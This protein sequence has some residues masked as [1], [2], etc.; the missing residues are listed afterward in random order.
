MRLS[1]II[2]LLPLAAGAGA[3][4]FNR[5]IRPILSGRCFKCHGFDAGARKA[6][7]RLD[8]REEAMKVIESGEFMKRVTSAD[9]DSIMPPPEEHEP[10]SAA[11]IA[12]LRQWIDEGAA[13]Q[14]HWAFIPPV[15]QPGTTID[16][17]VR[18]A[19]DREKLEP[20]PEADPL[21]LIRRASL[22]LTGLPPEAAAAHDPSLNYEAWVDALLASPH[23]GERLALDWLDAARYA[24]TNGY[25]TDAERQ[26][27]PWRDW[28]INAFN[29][30][31][32]FDQFTLEQ[33]AG[34]LLPDATVDQ[35]IATA[36]NRNHTVTNETG[37]IDEEY[38]AS[39]VSDRVETTAAT[40]LGL[41][42]GCARC[43]DHKYDPLTQRDYFSLYAAFNSIDEKGIIKEAAPMGAAPALRLP[44]EAQTAEL[45]ALAK[46]I[47]Q[48][49][50]ELKKQH[51]ALEAEIASWEPAA[52]AALPPA[53]V[54]GSVAH[55]S[56][57]TDARDYGPLRVDS[58][59][60]GTLVPG[61]GVKG[62]ATLLDATQYVEFAAPR[63]VERD[64]SF[65]LSVWINPGSSPQGCVASKQD[66]DAEARGFEILWYK[67]QPRI[68]LA[69]R[70]GHDGIEVVA[71]EKFSGGQ[72]RHLVITYDGCSKA[73][74]L[75]VYVDGTP[76]VVEVRR[77]SLSGSIASAEPWR[78]GWKATG[79][80]FE[81]GMD[82]FRLFDRVLPP[83]EVAALH[84]REFMEGTLAV[85]R[86]ERPRA[87][88]DKLEAWYLDHNGPAGLALLTKELADLRARET[89]LKKSVLSL[90]VMQEMETPRETHILIR[91]QY[92]Q[93]GAKVRFAVP[94]WLGPL[95][96]GA[97]MNRL[98]L[99][100]WLLSKD[101]PLTARVAVNRLWAQCFG[102]GLV[103][104][105]NDFG[106]Q[107]ESPTNAELLD[108]LAVV[109][110]DGDA[111][112]R[113]WDVKALL[114]R[115]VMS[116]T[117]RQ[118]SSFTPQL[119]ARDPDN[120]LLARGPRFRLPGEIIR[121]Q[122]LAVS[123]LLVPKIG[124]P[125]VKPWQPP[126]L[127]EAVS[128]N[129]EAVYEPDQG[130]AT[131]RRGL[132][133]YWKRQSPPPDLLTFDS[134]TREVCTLRRPRTNTPLQ[135]LLLLNDANYQ[136]AARALAARARREPGDPLSRAFQLATG[137]PPRPAELAE[138]R[139]FF[140]EQQRHS[141]EAAAW[142]LTASL[143]LNLD[144]FQTQH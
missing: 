14:P 69:H 92:D 22:A 31:M 108:H 7:L 42:L 57:D 118:A 4:E 81:G 116:A 106:H 104:T 36:F 127:W 48:R 45:A 113:P 105:P 1:P 17:I 129:G 140:D 79:I 63:P 49:Q 75:K 114:K 12:L 124:G 82:E 94:S 21:V 5:D 38:R 141:S 51:P 54:A 89:E 111:T 139:R 29:V 107:G 32:P 55:F 44:T 126:G 130:E 123:G 61:A 40:W 19:L 134:P 37:I 142:T 87:T 70:Y 10:L 3:V 101:N 18:A 78:I 47:Q 9:Q 85:P 43:H 77:D 73:A 102:E 143:L 60:S 24:D 11:Q 97:P 16:S 50:A 135:A 128:Y 56:F 98:G 76:S 74:G 30:N 53:P 110:R 46:D 121:D 72:W 35:R 62:R 117:S 52:L 33:I 8:Q 84:W 109:F 112:T 144:E 90:S 136:E 93:P 122:A 41:T 120:R 133:T 83:D 100:Q 67:A 2:L 23:F 65:T 15:S 99:A 25:Y 13:Y 27:W 28:V 125:S 59:T 138:L 95:P 20:S 68:N 115:I 88:Q 132:Y 91:G 6:D 71:K 39:Y 64:Q 80:G 86:T 66:S 131:R 26:A 103:R 137:R 58:T 96:P 34:D 119:L